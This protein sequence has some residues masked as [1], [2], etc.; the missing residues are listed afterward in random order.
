MASLKSHKKCPEH[1]KY[2]IAQVCGLQVREKTGHFMVKYIGV[3][4]SMNKCVIATHT[5]NE[6]I[7]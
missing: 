5:Q 1:W 2:F 7:W 4:G 6:L 3:G